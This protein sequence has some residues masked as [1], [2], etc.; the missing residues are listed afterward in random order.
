MSKHEQSIYILLVCNCI[1]F[2][3]LLLYFNI[4]F[5][6]IFY[7]KHGLKYRKQSKIQRKG[8]RKRARKQKI[9]DRGDVTFQRD[10][11]QRMCLSFYTYITLKIITVL[12]F[13]HSLHVIYSNS[14]NLTHIH[15]ISLSFSL[16]QAIHDDCSKPSS[17]H[18]IKY[19]TIISYSVAVAVVVIG[20]V[21]VLHTYLCM[22]FSLRT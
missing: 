7:Y 20:V 2:L 6:Y 3:L 18:V 17:Y 10:A 5:T 11:M 12:T 16:Y 14:L 1:W 22:L 21:V 19:T 4:R 15:C 8:E 13:I 9:N